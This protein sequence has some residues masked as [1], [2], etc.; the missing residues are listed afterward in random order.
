[1]TLAN[2]SPCSCCRDQLGLMTRPCPVCG[3]QKRANS[4]VAEVY[5]VRTGQYIREEHRVR[6]TAR[7]WEEAQ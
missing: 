6:Y 1:M 2:S 5:G 7:V 4:A 3:K